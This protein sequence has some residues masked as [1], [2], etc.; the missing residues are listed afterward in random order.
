M[1]TTALSAGQA[2][3]HARGGQLQ[4]QIHG[5]PL[6]KR[7]EVQYV[8]FATEIMGKT[9]NDELWNTTAAEADRT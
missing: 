8:Q 5:G 9:G 6:H 4:L 1:L 3:K 7:E 2:H